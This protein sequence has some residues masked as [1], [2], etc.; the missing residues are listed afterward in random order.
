MGDLL[1]SMGRPGSA[2][3]EDGTTILAGAGGVA[4]ADPPRTV[5]GPRASG[6]PLRPGLAVTVR[7]EDRVS[8]WVGHGEL[9]LE[10]P[11]LGWFTPPEFGY[12]VGQELQRRW[13]D[14]LVGGFRVRSVA[15]YCE[16]RRGSQVLRLL[17]LL[18][19]GPW[20]DRRIDGVHMARDVREAVRFMCVD[21]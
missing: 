5:E 11:L 3:G 14:Q 4:E 9:R 10:V 16:E 12:L 19:D 18:H 20:D 17:I 1:G 13:A 2:R 15:G 6:P 8:R 7:W 21:R